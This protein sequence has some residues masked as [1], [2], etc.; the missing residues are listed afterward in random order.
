[1]QWKKPLDSEA[2]VCL[3]DYKMIEIHTHST[4]TQSHIMMKNINNNINI[5]MAINTNLLII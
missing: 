5:V 2:I 4:Q 3:S 1:M